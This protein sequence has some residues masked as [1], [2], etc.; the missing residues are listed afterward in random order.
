[1][2]I[3]VFSLAVFTFILIT[4]YFKEHSLQRDQPYGLLT[5]D[6]NILSQDDLSMDLWL[7]GKVGD[8]SFTEKMGG[9]IYWQCFPIKEVHPKYEAWVD[10][11]SHLTSENM[12]DLEIAVQH[13]G[14]RHVYGGRRAYGIE[15]CTDF[16]K[17][18]KR[19]TKGQEYICLNGDYVVFD[20]EESVDSATHVWMWNKMKTRIGCHANYLSDCDTSIYKVSKK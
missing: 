16:M 8:V 5:P 14:I 2:M 6:Y 11:D 4:P 10:A 3:K 20:Q 18:F 13:K 19:L 15:Y 17:N 1:M 7:Q 9:R 12:C